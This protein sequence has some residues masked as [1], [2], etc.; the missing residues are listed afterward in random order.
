MSKRTPGIARRVGMVLGR[1]FF[2]FVTLAIIVGTVAWGP[3]VSLGL[4]LVL[5]YIVDRLECRY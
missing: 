2:P 3:W 1:S 5:W 4:T